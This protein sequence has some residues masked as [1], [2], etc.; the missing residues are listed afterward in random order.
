MENNSNIKQ[1]AFI[2]MR[3]APFFTKI[4]SKKINNSFIN[5]ASIGTQLHHYD[6]N[7]MAYRER[8]KKTCLHTGKGASIWPIPCMKKACIL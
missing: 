5:G 1:G 6:I 8:K 4:S 3:F 7:I 2:E